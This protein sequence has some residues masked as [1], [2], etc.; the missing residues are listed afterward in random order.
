MNK[1]FDLNIFF[2]KKFILIKQNIIKLFLFSY[3]F[4]SI[5]ISDASHILN[6]FNLSKY[7][8]FYYIFLYSFHK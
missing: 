3:I 8:I 1:E 7:K 4:F 6:I 2:L 5:S